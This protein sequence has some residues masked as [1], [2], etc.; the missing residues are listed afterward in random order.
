M[1]SSFY[2]AVYTV[3]IKFSAGKYL[4]GWLRVKGE[5]GSDK[6]MSEGMLIRKQRW[7]KNR[8]TLPVS[9]V[10]VELLSKDPLQIPV[11]ENQKMKWNEMQ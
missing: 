5:E 4:K 7:Q 6:V 1:S 8:C 11:P 2:N 10:I 3:D 9:A